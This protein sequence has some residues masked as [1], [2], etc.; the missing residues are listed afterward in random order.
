MKLLCYGVRDV[1]KP[2]FLELNKK[3]N[4]ELVLTEQYLNDE[5]VHL[6]KGC[7]AV[8]LRGNCPAHRKNLEI[9]K[10]YG[11]KYVLTRTVG[12]NHID[13]EAAKELGLKVAYV[14]FYS[15]NAIAE[16]AVSLA[17]A[18][19][20]NTAYTVEKTHN[21][22]YTVDS[23][24]FAKE[25]RKSTVGIVGLGKIGFTSAQLFK[26]LGANVIGYDV[27]EKDYLGDVCKQVSLEQLLAE[28]DI[29][30]VHVPYFKGSNDHMLNADFVSKMKPGAVLVN[31][32][33]G[34]LQDIEAILAAVENGKLRGFATDVLENETKYFNKKHAAVVD[35]IDQKIRSLYPRVLVTPHIG[36]YTDEAVSNMVEYSYDNLKEFIETG[37]S[38]NQLA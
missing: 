37:K 32:S 24:M 9:Y 29:I 12:Y 28:S 30:S 27:V 34:E 15:P 3:F 5:S 38:K 23:A 36:S 7:E 13:L 26:G 2:F 21:G 31:T 25:I 4:Y 14:P 33:R 10:E 11:V 8:M 22:D 19:A 17:F 1:E 35:E 18:L 20:R 16:L 6:A